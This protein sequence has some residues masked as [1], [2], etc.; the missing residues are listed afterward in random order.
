MEEL[1]TTFLL[2]GYT[3]IASI[4]D[5]LMYGMGLGLWDSVNKMQVARARVHTLVEKLKASSML[6][7][8]IISNN[9]EYFSMHAVVSQCLHI[10]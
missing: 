7:D 1:K 5:L 4:R 9:E 8:G 3:T 6:L 2:I 10:N